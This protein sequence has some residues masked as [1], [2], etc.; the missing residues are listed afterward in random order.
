MANPLD[1]FSGKR[2]SLDVKIRTM[3]KLS[4]YFQRYGPTDWVIKFDS[5]MELWRQDLQRIFPTDETINNS[6]ATIVQTVIQA[7]TPSVSEPS[8]TPPAFDPA[9]LIAQIDALSDALAAHIAQTIV[10]G[11]NSDVVGETD[12]QVLEKK[13]IGESAWRNAR[14]LHAIQVNQ[15]ENGETYTIPSGFNMVI[16]GA[17]SVNVGGMLIV[18]GSAGFV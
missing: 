18:D 1:S 6:I 15:I 14:F 12:E 10:H 4:E 5:A 17:F 13:T 11:T 2:G 3:P 7:G 8:A 9:P 16:A